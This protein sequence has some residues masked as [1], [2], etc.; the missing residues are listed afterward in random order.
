MAT[1]NMNWTIRN[2]MILLLIPAIIIV[3]TIATLFSL[4]ISSA[5]QKDVAYDNTL[6]SVRAYAHEFNTELSD[7][8]VKSRTFSSVLDKNTGMTRKD[9]LDI[10]HS[11]LVDNKNAIGI[12]VIFEP[13]AFDGQDVM[14]ANT[15]GHDA[16]GRF[17]AYWNRLNGTESLIPVVDIETSDWYKIP[18]TTKKEIIMEPLLYE[19]VL[20]TSYITPI[21]K[22]GTFAGTVG[23]DIPLE[24]LDQTVSQVKIFDTGY[25]FLVSNSGVFVSSPKKEYIGRMSLN[26][27]SR[28]KNNPNLA[29]M[30][31]EI[32]KG[33]EGYIG[34]KDPLTG[35]NVVMFYSP[36][37]AGNWSMVVVAPT[38]EM[39]AGV[40]QLG[41]VMLLIGLFSIVI[42]G[43]IIFI[44]ARNLSEPIVAMSKTADRIA[45]GDLDVHVPDGDGELGVLA[46]AFNNMTARLRE[47]ISRLKAKV[48]ELEDAQ[49]A[50]QESE[51]KYR[52]IL[53][54]IQDAFYRSSRDDK[55]IMASPSLALLLGYDSVDECIGKNTS[56]FYRHPA[57]RDTFKE[58]VYRCGSVKDYEVELIKKDG[59][60]LFVSANSHLYYDK[61]RIVAGIEGIYRD[62]SERKRAEDAQRKNAEELHAAYE[63]LTASQEELHINMDDLTRQEQALRESDEKIRLLLNS[64]A[65]AIYGLDMNGNCTFCNNSC[66]RLLGYTSPDELLGRNM[67]WQIHA[68]HSDGTHF[69]IE[70]CRIFK[71]FN[72]GEGTHVDDEVLWRSDGTSFPAEYWSY[73]QRRDGVV[74]GAVVTFLNISER[75]VAEN[76][77]QRVNQKLNVLSQLTRKDLTNQIFVLNSYLELAKHQ[78][79]G[80]DRII[81]TVQK[82]IRAIQSIHETIEY[83]KDY[84]D[85]GAK[86]PKWQNV[87]MAMLFG[88]SHISIGNIQHRLETENLEIFADPL[89]EK[90]CQRLFE[91]STKHGDHVTRIRVWQK[92]TPDGVTIFFEDDG[93]GISAEKKEQIF[94]RD[95][96][97]G[98]TSM[99]SLIFVREILDITGITIR[100]N[101]E[102]GKGARFEIT[103]PKGSYRNQDTKNRNEDKP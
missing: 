32:R 38:D 77:L 7:N 29:A 25:A 92:T 83:S 1:K 3:L 53:N 33:K 74:V 49:A 88:L 59:S 66:L 58:T 27:L 81:E 42:V 102:P 93:I 54:N 62:I 63:E 43:G 20:M 75:K 71:A 4:Q 46:N 65:E 8:L 60:S 85:M 30:A 5:A 34:M 17:A 78:L 80:Q 51:E 35:K 82:G 72:K 19:N 16:T 14:Y 56:T 24:N 50:L 6:N 97:T 39:L 11:L 28:E 40:A 48:A 90:V 96:S 95:E 45:S 21:I 87:N 70:E 99:R 37:R 61:S 47:L 12:G 55:V 69:P 44:V 22:N 76:S 2:R 86:P 13:G 26:E 41:S 64:T 89:L 23:I 98:R 94:L 52:S 15:P 103:V 9:V 68:K 67:H 73:P 10:Q 36:I 91:N 57:D 18:K 31:A 101:G 84:Q 100:E 79:E